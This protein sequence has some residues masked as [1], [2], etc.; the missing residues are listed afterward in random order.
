M[1]EQANRTVLIT[2]TSS[3]VGEAF[4]VLAKTIPK[5][6]SQSTARKLIKR[7]Y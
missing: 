4:A 5:R 2:G 3:G 7:S 1:S 6:I